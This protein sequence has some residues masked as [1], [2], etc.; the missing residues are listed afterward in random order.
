MYKAKADGRNQFRF[1]SESFTEQALE[2]VVLEANLHNALNKKE[3]VVYYQ[4]Q[5]N[6]Q[7]GRLCGL[8]AL[9]RWQHPEQGLISPIKFIPL[10]EHSGLI[11]PIGEWVLYETCQQMVKWQKLG[12]IQP[13]VSI[14]VNL[15]P[16][17]FDQD[18]LIEMINTVLI[19]TGLSH[20]ALELEITESTMMR[21]PQK[22]TE[23]LNRLRKL[24]VKLAIDDFGTG[25]SSLSHL[26]LLPLTKL[27]ID[28]SFVFS[29]PNDI[30]DIAISR[31]VIS[32]AQGL[33][34]EVLAEG[35][36]NKAQ[37]DFLR[38][39]GCHSGQGY[40]FSRP[41]S[42]KRIEKFLEDDKQT[43]L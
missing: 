10:A 16:V 40:L 1:Y 12:L 9:I 43:M 8:E 23:I 22:S 18:N 3:F 15:S 35:I 26:K 5:L 39:E 36:E 11:K 37:R 28:Q 32:L 19:E 31:S 24:G 38:D 27:K 33:S 20:S 42:A 13:N 2:R 14:S 17:Q 25:Y 41:L 34:L 4:P 29:I 30:N 7:S 21:N 6:L